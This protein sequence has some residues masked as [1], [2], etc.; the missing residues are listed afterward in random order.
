[1]E[2]YFNPQISH[3]EMSRISQRAV[4]DAQRFNAVGTREYLQKRGFLPNNVVRYLYRPLDIRWLYW[5]PET[6]LL[7]EKRSEYFPHIG[8]DNYWLCATQQNRKEFDPPLVTTRLTAF[9][10]V[11][12]G[13]NMFPLLLKPTPPTHLFE[14]QEDS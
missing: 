7:N 11:E 3:Q 10:V 14:V 9:H 5:E 6:K 13:A 2:N 4:D 1:M 12:R 8:E